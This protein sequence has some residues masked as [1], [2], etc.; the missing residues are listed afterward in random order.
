MIYL[1]TTETVCIGRTNK[2]FIFPTVRDLK[3]FFFENLS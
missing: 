1:I 2:V 3:S